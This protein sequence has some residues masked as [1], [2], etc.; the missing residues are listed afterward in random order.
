MKIGVYMMISRNYVY[1]PARM[2]KRFVDSEKIIWKLKA[3]AQRYVSKNFNSQLTRKYESLQ[4]EHEDLKE[5]NKELHVRADIASFKL[6]EKEKKFASSEA[7]RSDEPILSAAGNTQASG[8]SA[9]TYYDFGNF[10]L[11][12][13]SIALTGYSRDF[14][15]PDYRDDHDDSIE[16]PPVTLIMANYSMYSSG[17]KNG[18]YWMSKPFYS[19]IEPSYKLCL[20]VRASEN[21]SVFVR[22]M[23]GEFDDELDW[24]FN[25]NITIR[26]MAVAGTGKEKLSSEMDT[27]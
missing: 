20:S 27:G 8:R 22:L 25:A 12:Q 15:S 10:G 26:I 6:L 17:Q 21:L 5:E 16:G 4:K 13:A 11:S 2:R 7:I 18:K 9:A 19:R 14:E 24:P 1:M 3:S 23:R